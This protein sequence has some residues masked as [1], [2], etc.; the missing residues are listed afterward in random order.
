MRVVPSLDELKYRSLSFRRSLE[1]I[2][3]SEV[4][5]RSATCGEA[6]A[7]WTGCSP[8]IGG[9]KAGLIHG[10]SVSTAPYATWFWDKA[11]SGGQI[12]DQATHIINL[13]Q[14]FGGEVQSVQATGTVSRLLS[15][16]WVKTEDVSGL[17]MKFRNGTIG[18]FA[19]TWAHDAKSSELFSLGVR[20]S[21]CPHLRAGQEQAVRPRE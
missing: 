13:A 1:A 17:L 12:F 21:V 16:D 11:Q 2:R 14:L 18:T 15:D 9:E 20:A 19:N 6:A 5:K 10:Y 8:L 7:A 3:S 4:L